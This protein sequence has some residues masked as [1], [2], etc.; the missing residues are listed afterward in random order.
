MDTSFLRKCLRRSLWYLHTHIHIYTHTHIH[1]YVHTYICI[2]VVIGLICRDHDDCC[3]SIN[4]MYICICMHALRYVRT[5]ILVYVCIASCTLVEDL[6]SKLHKFNN[7]S[8]GSSLLYATHI[9]LA[10][11]ISCLIFYSTKPGTLMCRI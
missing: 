5:N 11:K 6:M 10:P 3:C 8:I 7:V 1:T 2:Y 4:F 9:N